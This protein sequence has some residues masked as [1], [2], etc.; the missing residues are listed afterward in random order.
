[1]VC[2]VAAILSF[3][4]IRPQ[5]FTG[6]LFRFQD[7][8]TLTKNMLITHVKRA[9][10]A[11]GLNPH[12]YSGHSFRIG[13]ATAAAQAGIPDHQIKMLGRWESSA[14]LLYIRTPPGQLSALSACLI[15]PQSSLPRSQSH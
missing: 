9:V 11:A 6:P 4:A 14:Y 7:G 12:L 3:I 2:P 5:H 15:R 13:A 8:S 1:M 10:S